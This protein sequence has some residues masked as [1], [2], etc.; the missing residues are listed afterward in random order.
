MC[1][2][3]LLPLGCPGVDRA[4][5]VADDLVVMDGGVEQV[6]LLGL[7]DI[8]MG[9]FKAALQGCLGPFPH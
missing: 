3:S 7:R 6:L 9:S 4:L 2:P 8:A 1:G 5:R